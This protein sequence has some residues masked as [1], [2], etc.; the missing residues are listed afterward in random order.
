MRIGLLIAALIGLSMLSLMAWRAAFIAD[1]SLTGELSAYDEVAATVRTASGLVELPGPGTTARHD[2]SA[3]ELTAGWRGRPLAEWI[4][5]YGAADGAHERRDARGQRR[6]WWHDLCR[7]VDPQDAQRQPVA[8]VVLTLA[9]NDT[10]AAIDLIGG[11]GRV[12]LAGGG[13]PVDDVP[14]P[15]APEP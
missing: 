8:H 12:L 15:A 13:V 2:A 1:P 7:A 5:T 4:A 11:G 6:V 3:E 14:L 10:I 9:A